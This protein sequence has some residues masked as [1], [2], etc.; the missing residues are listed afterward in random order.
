M[1]DGPV[2]GRPRTA[3]PGSF[4]ASHPTI[5][6]G[7]A[8]DSTALRHGNRRYISPRGRKR[9]R[10]AV[11]P[12]MVMPQTI[13][14][15][16]DSVV[17]AWGRH[18]ADSAHVPDGGGRFQ[19]FNDLFYLGSQGRVTQPSQVAMELV[20]I[21]NFGNMWGFYPQSYACEKFRVFPQRGIFHKSR[22]WSP[23]DLM[24]SLP[25]PGGC[26]SH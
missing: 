8:A 24:C 13:L 11:W 9:R 4:G 25:L 2:G 5:A 18:P 10:M 19:L 1:E 12:S 17:F 21:P 26:D 14:S 3:P 15:Y 20:V 6:N 23:S 7:V 22:F 16:P